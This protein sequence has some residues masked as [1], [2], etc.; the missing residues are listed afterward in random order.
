MIIIGSIILKDSPYDSHGEIIGAIV[1]DTKTS[2]VRGKL[3]KFSRSY[4]EMPYAFDDLPDKIFDTFI[5]GRCKLWDADGDPVFVSNSDP[6]LLKKYN[7]MLMRNGKRLGI[8]LT[9]EYKDQ[10]GPID[11][12]LLEFA[13]REV[14][15]KS[16]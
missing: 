1:Q 16:D 14:T 4:Q 5:S 11:H 13:I 15:G 3:N 9:K 12:E 2:Q 10:K 8:G 6:E 7:S